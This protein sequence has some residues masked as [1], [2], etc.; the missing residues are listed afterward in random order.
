MPEVG[1][2]PGLEYL[3]GR[4]QQFLGWLQAQAGQGMAENP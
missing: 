2:R 3:A 1:G 4:M